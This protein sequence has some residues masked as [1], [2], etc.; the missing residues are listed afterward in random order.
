MYSSVGR[1]AREDGFNEFVHSLKDWML[2][3]QLSTTNLCT[4]WLRSFDRTCRKR[5]VRLRYPR[6]SSE[7]TLIQVKC[8][9]I[10]QRC[11]VG[12]NLWKRQSTKYLPST[13]NLVFDCT[14]SAIEDVSGHS[15]T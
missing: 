10:P 8:D 7:V 2:V 6:V 13:S 5:K 15:K 9:E 3:S 12:L 14:K 11:G 4:H 1:E